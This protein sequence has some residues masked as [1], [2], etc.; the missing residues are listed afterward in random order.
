[1]LLMCAISWK[2]VRARL[3][4]RL[5]LPHL[6]RCNPLLPTRVLQAKILHQSVGIRF[7]HAMCYSQ[8]AC[9]TLVTTVLSY[10]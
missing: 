7:V 3:G 8:V 6:P 10:T 4:L 1:M 5:G 9:A 2:Y